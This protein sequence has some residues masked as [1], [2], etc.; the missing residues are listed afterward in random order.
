MEAIKAA[1]NR[2]L[3][4]SPF[5]TARIAGI[6]S[7]A[8]AAAQFGCAAQVRQITDHQ[9]E[10]VGEEHH[11]PTDSLWLAEKTLQKADMLK[12]SP[13]SLNLPELRKEYEELLRGYGFSR[14]A[15]TKET[16]K[17]LNAEYE[18]KQKQ[19][20]DF[21]NQRNELLKQAYAYLK[22]ALDCEELTEEQRRKAKNDAIRIL[23]EIEGGLVSALLFDP[24]PPIPEN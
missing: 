24:L 21:S 18:K 22:T 19:F 4:R 10:A 3:H 12:I 15:Q 17:S 7:V 20:L 16:L 14:D 13:E 9:E 23:Q 2:T 8:I 6:L 11:K 5:R 1:E